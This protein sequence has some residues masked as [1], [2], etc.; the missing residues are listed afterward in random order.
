MDGRPLRQQIGFC[1]TPLGRVAYAEVGSGPPLVL[2]PPWIGHVEREWAFPEVR[3]FVGALARDHRVVRY[4]RPGTGLSD[5]LPAG[6]PPPSLDDDVE[7]VG[8]LLDSLQI[9]AAAVLGFST[10][11]CV[12]VALAARRPG[13][14]T[15]LVLVGAFADGSAI[16]PPGLG[17][18]LV[19][20]VR[21]HWGA[22]SRALADVWVPGTNRATRQAF[23]D[24]QRASADAQDA[25]RALEA[26]YATDVR[27]EAPRV[28]APT[29]VLHR[30]GDRA[31]P[32][33]LGRELAALIPGARL[34]LL[35]GELHPPW[36][37]DRD[38]VVREVRAFLA[39][40]PADPADHPVD[41]ADPADHPDGPPAAPPPRERPGAGTLSERE[42][43]V[44]RLVAAGL[45]DE[46]IAATLVLSPH[47][48][49]RHVS[50]IR[51]KLDAP[52]RAAAAAAA[53]RSGLI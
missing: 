27:Q 45:T 35:P 33:Q 30:R 50:N 15:R 9:P 28:R 10:G 11:G 42:R 20:T 46:R 5:R 31:I 12:A 36:L 24:L 51:I 2:P 23:A 40:D 47:T 7:V 39:D 1:P 6:A 16:A 3:A 32:V 34:T 8:A 21:A 19:A 29:L 17:E 44:L 43:E 22:G 41:P 18:A 25:A 37:G 13:V 53:A 49:H 38:A 4:D 52:S 26:V 14:V 48:V